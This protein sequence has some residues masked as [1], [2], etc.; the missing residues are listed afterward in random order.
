VKPDGTTPDPPYTIGYDAYPGPEATALSL[1]GSQLAWSSTGGEIFVERVGRTEPPRRLRPRARWMVTRA[2]FGDSPQR[3]LAMAFL[4][5]DHL[6]VAR[7]E[8]N[9]DVIEVSSGDGI[10]TL[11]VEGDGL[12]RVIIERGLIY[13][14]RMNADSLVYEVGPTFTF[15][16]PYSFGEDGGFVGG[17]GGGGP[18][19]ESIV[20]RH[21]G[22]KFKACTLSSLRSG[23][24]RAAKSET[25]DPKSLPMA[26]DA[27]GGRWVQRRDESGFG[28]VTRTGGPAAATIDLEG[29]GLAWLSVSPRSDVAILHGDASITAHHLP[30]GKPIWSAATMMVPV[31]SADGA[32]AAVVLGGGVA[33]LDVATG[34]IVHRRCAAGFGKSEISSTPALA[35]SAA[36]EAPSLCE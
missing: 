25:I 31:F 18:D 2:L 35:F 32:R 6:L 26:I 23:A 17:V 13:L 16:G 7:D 28:Y 12:R 10:A 14:D 19:G 11:Q 5:E 15:L 34:T 8:R 27:A 21:D 9:L 20:W 1:D 3:T 33:V 30:D 22:S 36:P 29:R 4:D 24:C